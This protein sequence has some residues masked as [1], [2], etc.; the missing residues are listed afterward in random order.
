MDFFFAPAASTQSP[1]FLKDFDDIRMDLYR[2][3]SDGT[4]AGDGVVLNGRN[5]VQFVIGDVPVS[6]VRTEMFH[7]DPRDEAEHETGV[8]L[9]GTRD[10]LTKKMYNR[11]GIN[12]LVTQ[13]D[14]YDF[15]VARTLAADDLAYAWSTMTDDMQREAVAAC[16][17]LAQGEAHAHS[18]ALVN[19][20]H[21]GIAANLWQHVVL[22]LES[23][24]EYVPP[25]DQ[26]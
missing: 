20:R 23:N 10:I 8:L 3:V 26:R 25:L 9:A 17:D 2:L 7:G 11:L 13:R 12:R 16:R 15:A 4:I 22:L 14:A 1:L 21:E 6:F 24:L 5:Q 18:R 19:P